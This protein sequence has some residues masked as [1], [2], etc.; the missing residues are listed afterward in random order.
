MGSSFLFEGFIMK[1]GDLV[2]KKPSLD[3]SVPFKRGLVLSV[4]SGEDSTRRARRFWNIAL[5]DGRV[6][7][8]SEAYVECISE[9]R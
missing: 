5:Q 7:I 9:S 2:N 1:I 4:H 3:G 6:V 8:C